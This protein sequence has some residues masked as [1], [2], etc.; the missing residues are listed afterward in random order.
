MSGATEDAEDDPDALA[1]EYV[2]GLLDAAGLARATALRQTDARF[3]AAVRAWETRLT[4]LAAA[5]PEVVPPPRLW[6]AIEAA[7]A[8][9]PAPARLWNSV[10]FWRAATF[11]LAGLGAA[12]LAAIIVFVS[13]RN[14]PGPTAVATLGTGGGAF[15]ATAE[16]ISGGTTLV[17][18]P[19]RVTVP[20][21]KSDELWLILPAQK[22][23][24]LGLLDATHP[25]QVHIAASQAF[26]PATAEL[27]ISL[28][29]PGGSP[30]G[31]AT[32]PIIA[33]ATFSTL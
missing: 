30:T 19:V 24:A 8:P 18:T 27:A 32:G 23:Q 20:A 10:R 4:P 22:P 33:A 15:I 1:G 9:P 5:L 14:P 21:N 31:A 29:P 25:V 2:L 28:E 7:T 3:D 6:A 12:G 17:I 16:Q 11:G 13:N 26:A